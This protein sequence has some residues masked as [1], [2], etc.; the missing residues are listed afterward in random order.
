MIKFFFCAI[1]PATI[2]LQSCGSQNNSTETN[3]PPV[4]V[5]QDEIPE[6]AQI[7]GSATDT[8]IY[9]ESPVSGNEGSEVIQNEPRQ[10]NPQTKKEIEKIT[11]SFIS[12]G[13]GIDFE[14]MTNYKDFIDNWKSSVG[15]S[16][17]YE[18]IGWGRE[19]ET[20]F[21][22]DMTNISDSESKKFLAETREKIKNNSLVQIET[23][24]Q[25]KESRI[26]K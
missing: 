12:I 3:Q 19:G 6:T 5:N 20:D 2:T 16:V 22:I 21:C 17:S 9:N 23:N 7:E 25:C 11:V 1:L 13:E 14:A 18:T 4:I 10:S 8:A 24:Q 15:K 26:R